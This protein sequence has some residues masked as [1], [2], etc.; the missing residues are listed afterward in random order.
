VAVRVPTTPYTVAAAKC[1]LPSPSATAHSTDVPE[2]HTAVPQLDAPSAE[3][4]VLSRLAPK[5][6]PDTVMLHPAVMPAFAR[7]T[8]LT[9]GAVLG[10]VGVK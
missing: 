5:L 10:P 2:A 1:R 8:K 9:T 3:V 4:G 7:S 6:S